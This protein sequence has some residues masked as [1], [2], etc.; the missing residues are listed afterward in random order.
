MPELPFPPEDVEACDSD[1]KLQRE[2]SYAE[3]SLEL[4]REMGARRKEVVQAGASKDTAWIYFTSPPSTWE[5]LCGREGWLL[6]DPQSRRQHDFIL[7]IMN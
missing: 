5:A 4:K 7:T 3:L 2:H 1:Q 6:Y